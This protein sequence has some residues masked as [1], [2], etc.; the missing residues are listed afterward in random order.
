MSQ[1]TEME[2]QSWLVIV[3]ALL[4]S[5][6]FRACLRMVLLYRCRHFNTS[7][8]STSACKDST[9]PAVPSSALSYAIVMANEGG[10]QCGLSLSFFTCRSE[11]ANRRDQSGQAASGVALNMYLFIARFAHF[12]LEPVMPRR[13]SYF[14]LLVQAK[15]T[16]KKDTPCTAPSKRRWGFPALLAMPGGCATRTIRFADTCSDSARRLPP[17]WLR[18]S[19]AQQG[20]PKVKNF[21]TPAFRRF[22]IGF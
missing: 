1:L 7:L 17:A 20:A 15:V 22:V 9:S 14:F 16:K 10:I 18:Y 2:I 13:G 19:A 11:S 12:I 5:L 3:C 8:A 6:I 4:A 21:R